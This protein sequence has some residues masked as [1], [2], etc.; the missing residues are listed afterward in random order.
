MHHSPAVVLDSCVLYRAPLCDQLIRLSLA[1]FFRGPWTAQIHEEWI[2]AL[3]RNRRGDSSTRRY[4]HTRQGW[5]RHLLA[6]RMR[7]TICLL[8]ALQYHGIGTQLPHKV[9]M[10]I[11]RRAHCQH[12]DAPPM[13]CVLASARAR[14]TG[15]ERVEIDGDSDPSCAP[16]SKHSRDKPKE[17]GWRCHRSP[18]SYACVHEH[19]Q[20]PERHVLHANCSRRAHLAALAHRTNS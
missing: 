20:H 5:L 2:G 15:V 3:L 8:S 7:G 14:T 11:D 6:C 13:R 18:V 16:T 19:H 17:R 9:W 4:S 12:I 1:R 10:M